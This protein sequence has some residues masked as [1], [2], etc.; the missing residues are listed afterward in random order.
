MNFIGNPRLNS[1]EK[2]NRFDSNLVKHLERSH[3]PYIGGLFFFS[4]S[5]VL[6]I[7]VVACVSFFDIFPILQQFSY[8]VIPLPVMKQK[9][10]E[11]HLWKSKASGLHSLPTPYHFTSTV[12]KIWSDVDRHSPSF[13]FPNL[14][15]LLAERNK[16]KIAE[17]KLKKKGKKEKNS[18][19]NQKRV[20]FCTRSY[21]GGKMCRFPP[22]FLLYF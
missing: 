13:L 7:I 2:V 1:H 22:A 6:Q 21:P 5:L 10:K 19:E 3:S 11:S 20:G 15:P 16:R 12:L 8:S 14:I 4:I 17:E 9:E 18:G